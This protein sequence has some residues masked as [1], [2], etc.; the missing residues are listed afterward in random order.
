MSALWQ[1]GPGNVIRGATAR[2]PLQL[3]QIPHIF[4][5]FQGA[6]AWRVDP[7][8]ENALQRAYSFLQTNW[9]HSAAMQLIFNNNEPAWSQNGWSFVPVD[10]SDAVVL[11]DSL[12]KKTA[13][14]ARIE[15]RELFED[16]D[17]NITVETSA[18]RGR[19]ECSHI[20]SLDDTRL[21]LT[22]RDL[23]NTTIW[24]ATDRIASH[25]RGWSLGCDGTGDTFMESSSH[26]LVLET[27][28]SGSDACSAYHYTV[29]TG[30]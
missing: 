11:A 1:L 2:Y 3:R 26:Q 28:R 30:F 6:V 24:N 16:A 5:G 20:E 9:R 21:W 15:D 14:D 19:L 27:N 25:T 17:Y 18:I 8:A 29:S 22:E 23:T 4:I 10:L 7:V 12:L 13:S